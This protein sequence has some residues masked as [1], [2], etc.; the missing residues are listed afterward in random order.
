MPENEPETRTPGD[1]LEVVE[2]LLKHGDTRGAMRELLRVLAD[3]PLDRRTLEIAGRMT[4]LLGAS[5]EHEAF[6]RLAARPED[7]EARYALGYL[8]VDSGQERLGARYLELC[9]EGAHG[10]PRVEYELGYARMRA[11][12]LAAAEPLLFRAFQSRTL[13]DA[14]C[15]SAGALLV[16]CRVR[17]GFVREARA[18]LDALE[19][20]DG[21]RDEAQLDALAGLVSRAERLLAS[22]DVAREA[23]DPRDL[24]FVLAATSL[25][26]QGRDGTRCLAPSVVSLDFLAGLLRRLERV[27]EALEVS[28]KRVVSP[29][30]ELRPVI[31]AL[32]KRLKIPAADG[33]ESIDGALVVLR[34]PRDA[35]A[36][37]GSLRDAENRSF[38]FSLGV[39][40]R[41]DHA[42]APDSIGVLAERIVL[43]WESHI[44]FEGE[45]ESGAVQLPRV[46]PRD[47]ES[48]LR[49]GSE[50]ASAMDDLEGDESDLSALER[51]YRPLREYLSSSR[52][53][54]SPHRRT[55]CRL[56]AT[57]T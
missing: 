26:H 8:L 24:A 2:Q 37:L 48:E 23:R 13:A 17:G 41:L 44:R 45:D 31:T 18:A 11:G 42:L 9:L 43:P 55:M 21:E 49:L 57:P 7:P 5:R 16:E 47:H 40:P 46:V 20:W 56:F 53:N 54:A 10:E 36:H 12:D 22:E 6:T 38:V 28:P 3:H 14:E 52:G 50:L 4:H 15:F 33:L 1:A 39:D 27:L 25:L 35:I 34:H 19:R 29:V 30:A 51:Y 32:A